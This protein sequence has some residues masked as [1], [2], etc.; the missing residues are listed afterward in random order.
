MSDQVTLSAA[1]TFGDGK[2]RAGSQF[3]FKEDG[4]SHIWTEHT[5]S[6]EDPACLSC[7]YDATKAEITI[8]VNLSLA[9]TD[10]AVHETARQCRDVAPGPGYKHRH[11]PI[12]FRVVAASDALKAELQW[13]QMEKEVVEKYKTHPKTKWVLYSSKYA[14][15]TRLILPE[16]ERFKQA[17][18][19]R[20]PSLSDPPPRFRSTGRKAR[21]SHVRS[22][23]GR[24]QEEYKAEVRVV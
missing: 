4:D 13:D 14:E 12:P 7:C 2:V 17:L 16:K 8:K 9:E 19:D 21:P 6:G 5:D 3:T 22:W 10:L 11:Q 24:C 15:W 18:T 23:L 20:T 1:S